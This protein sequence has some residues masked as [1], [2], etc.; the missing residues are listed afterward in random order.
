MMLQ[1]GKAEASNGKTPARRKTDTYPAH[2]TV[3]KNT[4]MPLAA[5][6]PRLNLLRF[7]A[8]YTS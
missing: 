2:V 4:P 3:N 7:H 1:G 6:I 5:S 8:A